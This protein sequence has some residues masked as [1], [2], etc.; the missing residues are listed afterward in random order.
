MGKVLSSSLGLALLLAGTSASADVMRSAVGSYEVQVL[1]DGVPARTFFHQGESFVLGQRGARYTLRIL[2]H[3][4]QRVEAVVSVD[5]RDAIDGR[6]ADYRA[7]RGYLVSPYGHI[8]VDGWRLSQAEAAAFRF[9]GVAN[10]YAART[11]SAREVGVIG[12][13]MF[14]ERFEGPYRAYVPRPVPPRGPYYGTNRGDW[15]PESEEASPSARDKKA[16]P[17][18]DR[19]SQAPASPPHG[20]R[21]ESTAPDGA[22]AERARPSLRPGLGTAFGERVE[23]AVQE[24]PFYRQ[25]ASFPSAVLGL[26]YNDR[27]G[28]YAMGID[29]D[30]SGYP[31]DD[32]HLRR[33]AQPFPVPR[34]YATPPTGW[35]D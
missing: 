10:S 23:S 29:V 12:V 9:S 32:S 34:H 26:R 22:L 30:G 13:A 25:N 20:G 21:A 11:G 31:Y 8:E 17:A 27:Q 5:G 1:V 18:D 19:A 6:P 16:A 28:L 7:K 33:T 24:V 14:P 3:T 15:A 4:G 2:N 35:E